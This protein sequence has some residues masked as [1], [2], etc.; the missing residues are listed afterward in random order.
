MKSRTNIIVYML[1]I[2]ILTNGIITKVA[3]IPTN[4]DLNKAPIR[5]A[6]LSPK[7]ILAF[8]KLN[9]KK[10]NIVTMI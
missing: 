5:Y 7:K 4:K 3:A 9:I 6:P 2:W 8:G 1:Y 10:T